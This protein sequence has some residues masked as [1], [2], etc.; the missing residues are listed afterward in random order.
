MQALAWSETPAPPPTGPLSRRRADGDA[1]D[2]EGGYHGVLRNGATFAPGLS[3]RAFSLDGFH[4]HVLVPDHSDLNPGIEVA[5]D[6]WVNAERRR[7]LRPAHEPARSPR[8]L[9][10]GLRRHSRGQRHLGGR[11][12]EAGMDGG[13]RYRRTLGELHGRGARPRLPRARLG[14]RF[15]RLHG[16]AIHRR[17]RGVLRAGR[18]GRWRGLRRERGNRRRY[19]LLRIALSRRTCRFGRR[20][21]AARR[22]SA[23]GLHE[24]CV[25]PRDQ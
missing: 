24:P 21:R 18:E 20:S 23:R 9:R 25:N 8:R 12:R 11:H 4:D 1:L 7:L 6:L 22:R 3:G 19:R 14:R 10:P 17:K 16:L 5:V 13:Y 15:F 2:S